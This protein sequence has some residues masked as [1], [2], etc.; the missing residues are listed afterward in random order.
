MI[1]P[2][3]FLLSAVVFFATAATASALPHAPGAFKVKLFAGASS[4]ASGPD[5]ITMLNG[6]VFVAWQNGVGPTGTPAGKT[7]LLVE[8]GHSGNVVANWPLAGKIDGI[9]A[10]RNA[11][12]ATVNED[13]NSSLYTVKPGA[14]KSQQVVHYTYS[15][16]PD[17]PGNS[18]VHTGGGADA[19]SVLGN[20]IL[21]IASAPKHSGRTAA[22]R[23]VLSTVNGKPVARLSPT[24]SD[25]AHA[26]DALTGNRVKLH[27]TDPDSSTIVPAA[28]DVFGG[29]LMISSQANDELIFAHGIGSGHT[30]LNR[31]QLTSGANATKASVDDVRWAPKDGSK[32]Y[33]VD[34]GAN[35]IY[36]VTGP[37]TA[38]EA[39][40]SMDTVGGKSLGTQVATLNDGSGELSPF[41][42]G[43]KAAKGLL[44]TP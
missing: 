4:G 12:V 2:K 21:I 8:Y 30:T 42:K 11:I 39:L 37:F 35:R 9:A 40:A 5:D 14:A 43:L 33:V 3:P 13:G 36:R 31:L 24:F 18:P 23:A 25:N 16:A 26:T 38:G 34:N 17:S 41:L 6:H 10:A 15:P 7:G 28:A 29:D 22:F 20:K 19:V 32:L 44:F 27:L 1:S